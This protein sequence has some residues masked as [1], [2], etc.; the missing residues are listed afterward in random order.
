MATLAEQ[1]R[2]RCNTCDVE[3]DY[4]KAFPSYRGRQCRECY[5]A[6]MRQYQSLRPEQ[7]RRANLR[8]YGLTPED[9]DAM[10]D[11]QKGVCA[12]CG[13]PPD[14]SGNTGHRLAVDHCHATG[15]VRGLLC[16]ECNL[17]LG[18]VKDDP[19]RLRA[20]VHYLGS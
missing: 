13:S 18:Y 3:K 7:V 1:T 10:N 8:R 2:V 6:R 4:P 20:L 15:E 9:Y 14:G 12:A 11:A 17:A 19:K 16:R 5:N